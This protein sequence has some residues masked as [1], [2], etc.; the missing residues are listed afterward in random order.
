MREIEAKIGLHPGELELVRGRLRTCGAEQGSLDE[1]ENLLFDSLDGHLRRSGQGLRLRSF[2]GRTG[3]LFTYKGKVERNARF[4][5][6]EEIE[7]MAEDGVRLRQI[8]EHLGFRA[9]TR[10]LKQREHW[11]L[12]ATAVALDRLSFGDY[13]EVEG[14]PAA[15]D[16]TLAQ[17]GLQGRPHIRA[18]YAALARR[19]GVTLQP[20]DL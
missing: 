19:H 3:T 13:I 12:D 14:E 20:D 17:L 9:T 7:V 4:K 6:R 5:S 10:Y 11:N 2:A 15:I 18:S 1:E 8:L 16:A